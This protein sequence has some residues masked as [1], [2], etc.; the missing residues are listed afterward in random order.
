MRGRVRVRVKREGDV[1]TGKESVLLHN[2]KITVLS[3]SGNS[4][5]CFVS[6]SNSPS[7]FLSRTEQNIFAFALSPKLKDSR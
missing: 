5:D 2:S 1:H 3:I 6:V 4:R 7:S